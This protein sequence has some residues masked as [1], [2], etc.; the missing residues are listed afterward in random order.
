MGAPPALGSA[1][2]LLH[3]IRTP[4]LAAS[5]QSGVPVPCPME[6]GFHHVPQTSSPLAR[7]VQ[8]RA[9]FCTRICTRFCDC[10]YTL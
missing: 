8:R 1:L 6:P 4:S 2:E 5:W 3:L 9:C 7:R 10:F